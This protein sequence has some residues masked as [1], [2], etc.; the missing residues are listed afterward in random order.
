MGSRLFDLMEGETESIFSRDYWAGKLF[1]W[2][3]NNE[4]FKVR[5]FRFID[6]FPCLAD[7]NEVISHLQQYFSDPALN[8]PSA[9][10]WGIKYVAPSWMTS[11]IVAR[12]IGRNIRKVAAQFIA[13][14]SP[15]DAL[16]VLKELRSSGFAFS[17]DLLGEAVVSERE[18]DDYLARYLHLLEYLDGVQEKLPPL[19]ADAGVVLK[20]ESGP[21]AERSM[22]WQQSPRLNVS[23]KI[24]AMYSQMSGCGFE[25]SLE[26]ARERLRPILRRAMKAAAFI[27]FDMEHHGLKDLT[28]ALYRSLMEEAEFRGYPHT[29]IVIQAYL[30][31]SESDLE[32]MIGWADK[33]DSRFTVRLVKGAYWDQEVIAAKQKNWPVPVFTDKAQTD[34]NFERLAGIILENRGR[35]KLACGS[36]NIR[37]ISAVAETAKELGATGEHVEF[38]VLFGM[39]RPVRNALRKAGL[40]VRVYCPVG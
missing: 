32:Q 38:Q 13:G 24:S 6:V 37:T 36:H 20:F 19:G 8:F 28:L 5:M 2:C 1:D 34:A 15:E 10:N 30:R 17:L 14:T 22:D 3:M 7:S 29:G 9:V 35:I 25:H 23:V 26:K 4:E 12:A 39:G 31:E 18:A 11:R 33:S 16:A 21:G 40:H 27:N